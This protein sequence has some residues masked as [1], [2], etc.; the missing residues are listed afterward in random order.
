LAGRNA[1]GTQA[2]ATNASAGHTAAF[3]GAAAAA[4]Q[5]T[6]LVTTDAA[7]RA[8]LK[9]AGPLGGQILLNYDLPTKRVRGSYLITHMNLRLH[10]K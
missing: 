1:N 7:L 6:V 8:L 4:A 5:S 9:D 10:R 2:A 3:N